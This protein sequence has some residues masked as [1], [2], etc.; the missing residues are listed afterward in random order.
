MSNRDKLKSLEKRRADL[1]IE[2]KDL[3]DKIPKEFRDVKLM[4]FNSFILE[5]KIELNI[6]Y[7]NNNNLLRQQRNQNMWMLKDFLELI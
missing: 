5:F 1:E 7:S 6:E 4:H 3:L 2:I